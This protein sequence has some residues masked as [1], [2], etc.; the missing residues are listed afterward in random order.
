MI[1]YLWAFIM[2]FSIV[3]GFFTGKIDNVC[4][5]ILLGAKNSV[6]FLTFIVGTMAFWTGIINIAKESNATSKVSKFLRP[7]VKL[8]FPE[9]YKDQEIID[10]ICLTL[11]ANFLG[12]SNASTPLAI[13]AVNKIYKSDIEKDKKYNSIDMFIIIN[14][15]CVQIMP[16]MLV[17][18]RKKYKSLAPFEILPIIWLVSLLSSIF[19]VVILKL[20]KSYNYNVFCIPSKLKNKFK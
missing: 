5:A 19:G 11:S 12:I 1:N 3:C 13:R 17:S 10:S 8:L 18:L 14:I 15:A 16:S 6:D 4:E 20:F 7:L 9:I 2:I